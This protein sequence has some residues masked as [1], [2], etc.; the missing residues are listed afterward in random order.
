MDNYEWGSYEPRFG[1]YGVDRDRG[2]RVLDTDALG[3]DAAGAYRRIIAGL[4]AGDR[5]VLGP[6]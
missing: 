4:R 1:I 6:S 5:S 2:V 3:H